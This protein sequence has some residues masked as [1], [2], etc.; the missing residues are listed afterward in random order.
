MKYSRE[1]TIKNKV[2]KE[3]DI[4]RIAKLVHD[5]FQQGDYI[6]EYEVLFDDESCISG[7]DNREVFDSAEFKRRRSKRV[8]FTYKSKGLKNTV[9]IKLYNSF[10]TSANSS[11]EITSEDR[12]WYNN[13]CNEVLSI[14]NE[15][16]KQR[17]SITYG[18]KYIGSIIIS[19]I[20]GLLFACSLNR[21]FA[22]MFTTSQIIAIGS[23]SCGLLVIVNSCLFDQIDKA[24]PNIE[25]SFGPDYLNKSQK[26]R[27][28]FGIAIPFLV[29]VGFF[30][31]GLVG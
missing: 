24:Y 15:I 1:I 11:V 12:R 10:L 19:I 20:E 26:L 2:I 18:V 25:F 31:L 4:L 29:D 23:L 21:I 30:V 22:N 16:E 3:D 28:I 14:L 27:K 13:L 8:W 6:E 7:A 9:E 17:F 5:Q